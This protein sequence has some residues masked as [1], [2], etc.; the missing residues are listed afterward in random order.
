MHI[1]RDF[2]YIKPKNECIRTLIPLIKVGGFN[3]P[4]FDQIRVEPLAF[5]LIA[6]QFSKK[7]T[8]R[9]SRKRQT[10]SFLEWKILL[11]PRFQIHV[12]KNNQICSVALWFIKIIFAHVCKL[13]RITPENDVLT[14]YVCFLCFRM[15]IT[16]V[17][18]MDMTEI[19]SS[20]TS[21]TP[22]L[23]NLGKFFSS[24]F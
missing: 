10:A 15:N 21:P 24:F 23:P 19:S 11:E 5:S 17:T 13:W 8:R 3:D 7:K 4:V 1:F 16:D 18:N 12:M 9:A 14:F 6:E 2:K 22:P 20:E